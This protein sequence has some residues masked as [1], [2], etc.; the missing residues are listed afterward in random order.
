[1]DETKMIQEAFAKSRRL[2]VAIGDETRQTILATLMTSDCEEGMRVGEITSATHLS[3]PAVSHHLK[4]LRDCG[5]VGM[6]SE[7]TRNFYF[8]QMGG[9]W[10]EVVK[11]VYL[12]ERLRKEHGCS[13]SDQ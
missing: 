2:L 7:G 8:I 1:M 5:L 13:S 3:R 4:I 10:D 11:L 9:E 6:R 12:I